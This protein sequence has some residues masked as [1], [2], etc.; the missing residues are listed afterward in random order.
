MRL[1][2]LLLGPI[3]LYGDSRNLNTSVTSLELQKDLKYSCREKRG[4]GILL[5][6]LIRLNSDSRK[7]NLFIASLH[8]Q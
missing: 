8:L 7:L 5:Q 1:Y 4:F 2:T 3:R 6:V